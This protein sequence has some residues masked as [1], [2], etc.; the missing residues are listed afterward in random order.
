MRMKA[1]APDGVRE[2]SQLLPRPSRHFHHM[3]LRGLRKSRGDQHFA[4]CGVPIRQIRA[5]IRPVSSRRLR[6][7]RRHLGHSINDQIVGGG[8]DGILRAHRRE[9]EESQCQQKVGSF[10][11]GCPPHHECRILCIHHQCC[12]RE[13]LFEPAKLAQ[14]HSGEVTLGW[15]SDQR[16]RRMTRDF[17]HCLGHV[18]VGH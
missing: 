7:R 2:K 1:P 3:K 17:C 8:D 9:H 16:S 14:D 15:R 6:Q 4:F 12:N 10:H 11:L 13:D 5:S 18:T